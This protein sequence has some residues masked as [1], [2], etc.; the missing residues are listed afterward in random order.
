MYHDQICINVCLVIEDMI[1]PGEC[2]K[3]LY[4]AIMQL[5]SFSAEDWVAKPYCDPP[6]DL[7]LLIAELGDMFA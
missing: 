7:V 1:G 3:Q 4:L 5:C 2:S 6:N